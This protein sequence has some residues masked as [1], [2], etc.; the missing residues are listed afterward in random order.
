MRPSLTED[1]EVEDISDDAVHAVEDE[2][3]APRD[4]CIDYRDFVRC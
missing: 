3:N 4:I 1:D 2:S